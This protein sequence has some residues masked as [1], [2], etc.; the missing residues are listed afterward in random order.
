MYLRYLLFLLNKLLFVNPNELVVPFKKRIE[1]N[2]LTVCSAASLFLVMS[3]SAFGLSRVDSYLATT[4]SQ[5]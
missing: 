4:S 2:C 5:W 3:R 1:R